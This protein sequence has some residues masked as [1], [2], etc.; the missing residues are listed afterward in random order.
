MQTSNDY[1]IG[2]IPPQDLQLEKAIIGAILLEKSAIYEVID[3]LKPEVF[4]S[5]AHQKI[6]NAII[7]LHN[8]KVNI[9][10]LTITDQLRKS[11]E[12]DEVGGAYYVSEITSNIG[13]ASHILD[14][15]QIV[16]ELFLR[17][18]V[19]RILT[20]KTKACYDAE[21]DIFKIYNQAQQELNGL[22]ELLNQ[23]DYHQVGEVMTERLETISKIQANESNIIGTNTG[24]S[25][26]NMIT[27]GFQAGDYVI[28]GARPSVGKTI[29]AIL[30]AK[31]CIEQSK[32]PVCFFSLEMSKERI[33]DRILSVETR[34]NSM[35][36]SSNKLNPVE[37]SL[38]DAAA[39]KYLKK[40]FIIIDTGGMTIQSIRNKAI[41]L[42]R[43][44]SFGLIV[45]DYIQLI[46]YDLKNK[47]SNDNLSYISKTVKSIAKECQ[48]PVLVLSQLKRN[49]NR[50]PVLSDLRDSG[51]LE[52]DADIVWFLHREDYEGRECNEDEKNRIDNMIAK[53]RNGEI[54]SFYTYRSNDWS[55]IGEITLNEFESYEDN[56]PVF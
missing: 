12:L 47:N 5:S 52:Q 29:T 3:L 36:I 46:P 43:T 14:H 33:S 10:I 27:N 53:N 11:K 7:E 20:E 39:A 21:E 8:R 42:N 45:I 24:F 48:C 18:E 30:V 17:R 51:S 54:A 15:A 34:I 32:R 6:Y 25:K 28:L 22:F 41:T 13:S 4:Y 38:L 23:Y 9:D 50:P 31:A 56:M 37:W 26:L 16:Y 1:N 40:N 49:E 35:N 19:I 55:Y 44:N 2:H